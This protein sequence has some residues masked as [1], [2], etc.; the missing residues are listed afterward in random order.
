MDIRLVLGVALLLLAGCGVRSQQAPEPHETDR[1]NQLV[2][3]LGTNRTYNS[4]T[5]IMN[6]EPDGYIFMNWISR[7]EDTLAGTLGQY[8]TP[9]PNNLGS[10]SATLAWERETER[11]ESVA[12]AA[13]RDACGEHPC[14]IDRGWQVSSMDPV[15]AEAS[16]RARQAQRKA[17]EEATA[18]RSAAAAQANAES[19]AR[20]DA[21]RAAGEARM[22]AKIERDFREGQ[23]KP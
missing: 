22:N 10:V 15:P 5:L 2:G 23:I 8:E 1:I 4:R 3:Q 17:E 21:E 20:Q 13:R 11:A 7:R 6:P 12:A 14:P 9:A 19:V 16:E 18:V